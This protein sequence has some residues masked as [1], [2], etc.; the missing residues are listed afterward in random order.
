MVGVLSFG[1]SVRDKFI[2]VLGSPY[3]DSLTS[4]R[5]YK[6]PVRTHTFSMFNFVCI[7]WILMTNGGGKFLFAYRVSCSGVK[8]KAGF[9]S[10]LFTL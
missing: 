4:S 6:K 8:V 7:F 5:E 9:C 3:V 10:E 1:R 2:L